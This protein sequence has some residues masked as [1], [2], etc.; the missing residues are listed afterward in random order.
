MLPRE[1]TELE[2]EQ[3]A[4]NNKEDDE[5]EEESASG[6]LDEETSDDGLL[7]DERRLSNGEARITVADRVHRPATSH[8]LRREHRC[9]FGVLVL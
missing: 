7:S 6:T 9:R 1:L 4:Q 8:I 2:A 3:G 5:E